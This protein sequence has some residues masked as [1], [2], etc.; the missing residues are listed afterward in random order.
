MI[1]TSLVC[2]LFVSSAGALYWSLKKNIEYMERLESV[3]DLIRSSIE[4]LEAQRD[5][6]E[7][8]SK[9]EV[10]SDE[11]VVRELIQDIA[12]A[13]VS[14]EACMTAL[15]QVDKDDDDGEEDSADQG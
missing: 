7:Q 2:L 1:F 9:I 15:A 8:K 14:V 12:I 11:P 4:V 6:I 10:F 3:G 5:K 13:K